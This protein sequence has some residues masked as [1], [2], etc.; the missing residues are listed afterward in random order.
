MN[1]LRQME[2]TV[3]EEGREWMRRRLEKRLQA[4]SDALEAVCPK[5]G[6]GLSLI[7]I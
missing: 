1:L 7:H 2:Q 3:L 4:A 6:Q 5:T